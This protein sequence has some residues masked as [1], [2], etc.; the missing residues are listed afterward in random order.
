MT[1]EFWALAL[2]IRTYAIRFGND[3]GL[4]RPLDTE[5]WIVEAEA[6]RRVRVERDRHLIEDLARI[7]QRDEAVREAFR[8]VERASILGR[9]R[10]AAPAFEGRRVGAQIDRHANPVA[11]EPGVKQLMRKRRPKSPVGLGVDGLVTDF[12]ARMVDLVER[13]RPPA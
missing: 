1:P 13:G 6:L 2:E 10:L 4:G 11:G 9:K 12:P 5:R 8:D 3:F 7:L